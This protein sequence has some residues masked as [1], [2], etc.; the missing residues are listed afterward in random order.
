MALP[1]EIKVSQAVIFDQETENEIK[2]KK[3]ND[4]TGTLARE[5]RFCF[6]IYNVLLPLF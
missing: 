5:C 3:K 6:T 4:Q 2:M 1:N